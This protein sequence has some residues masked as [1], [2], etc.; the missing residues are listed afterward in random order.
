MIVTFVP[1]VG[2]VTYKPVAVVY[3]VTFVAAIVPPLR[4]E[5]AT[6]DTVPLLVVS[7][8]VPAPNLIQDPFS[9]HAAREKFV[10]IENL[11]AETDVV[12]R[13]RL[14]LIKA[15]PEK[16]AAR[17]LVI[18][19]FVLAVGACAKKFAAIVYVVMFVAAIGHDDSAFM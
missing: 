11:A 4:E 6:C 14:P 5:V 12:P 9:H 15:P 2:A 10:V 1:A 13:V 7:V 3:V 16:S 8:T 19:T 18:V 17:G